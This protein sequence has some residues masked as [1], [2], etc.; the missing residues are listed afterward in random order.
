MVALILMVTKYL[1]Q[2]HTSG[3][4]YIDKK[5]RRTGK[6]TCEQFNFISG[7]ESVLGASPG[8]ILLTAHKTEC[9]LMFGE[10]LEVSVTDLE[11]D[12]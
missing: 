12:N 9:I 4:H 1:L 2:H 7:N 3:L 6:D 11:H 5:G 8:R 10:I